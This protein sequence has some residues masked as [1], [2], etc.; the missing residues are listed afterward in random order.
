[1]EQN[2]VKIKLMTELANVL[3][4]ATFEYPSGDSLS[5]ES[6]QILCNTVEAL[7]IHGL[8]TAF[9]QKKPR[10]SRYP[11]PNFWPFVSK[12]T[13]KAVLDQI[14]TSNQIKTEIGKSRAW[15]R[16]LLNEN[17][18]ENYL[19]LLSRNNITLSKFY[20][21]WAFLR[22][23]E[24]MNVLS[25]Y[26]KGLTRL[27]IEAPV[28]SFFLNTWTPTPLIL[29]G[30]IA[31]EPA[32]LKQLT[33]CR[34]RGSSLSMLEDTELAENAL[35]SLCSS[36][37][38][39]SSCVEDSDLGQEVDLASVYSHP[40]MLDEEYIHPSALNSTSS[41]ILSNPVPEDGIPSY[42]SCQIRVTRGAYRRIRRSSKS[43]TAVSSSNSRNESI[44]AMV[45]ESCD[46]ENVGKKVE[47]FGEL[48]N[49]IQRTSSSILTLN[50]ENRENHDQSTEA[51]E[52]KA[53]DKKKHKSFEY[54][55]ELSISSEFTVHK[56]PKNPQGN[57]KSWTCSCA[58]SD[59]APDDIKPKYSMQDESYNLIY[60]L[61]PVISFENEQSFTEL[62]DQIRSISNKSSDVEL[63][64][65]VS[66][67]DNL[68]A[69]DHYNEGNSL[70]G[71]GWI[72]HHRWKPEFFD[73]RTSTISL[74]TN[75]DSSQNFDMEIR[76]VLDET[77]NEVMNQ[78]HSNNGSL[79]GEIPILEEVEDML[80]HVGDGDKTLFSISHHQIILNGSISE[81]SDKTL[82]DVL[83]VIPREKGLDSQDFRCLSC[84]KSIGPTFASYRKCGFDEKYYCNGC[85]SKGDESI[86][87]SRLI[88]NWD[89]HPRHV[90][91]C[92]M[93]FIES[94]RDKAV[95]RLDQINPQIYA[96]SHALNAV[97]FLREKLSLS[98]MYL[99][100][101]RKSIAE[102]L[103][104]RISP[105]D[106]LYKDIHLYSFTDLLTVLSGYMENHLNN[107]F[108]FTTEHIRRCLL[109]SQKGFLCEI[110]ASAEV[111]Y[112]FQLE[113]TSR[114]LACFSVYHKNCLEKQRCPKCTRR[115]R[116]MQQQPNID[117]QY[118]LLDMD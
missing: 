50:N 3:K 21:K 41:P 109:C 59:G 111:I 90:C 63:E 13:H 54:N 1:M 11:E 47:N 118:L 96:H 14:A 37:E 82:I 101:C 91:R 113:V 83:T 44:S 73:G 80:K 117:S 95:L 8:K 116:Y 51:Y 106:Y 19:N 39:S 77:S 18:I 87:P 68:Y 65:S 12:Y 10:S 27:T 78:K 6:T 24:R 86:I 94:I 107:L 100:S 69:S 38:I 76:N 53:V 92:N 45:G 40:S 26:M 64:R 48:Y 71:K 23:T 93:A 34:C 105:K 56:M 30:L 67:Q 103:E 58:R 98:A 17:T 16:I 57:S 46:I 97:K 114:C 7:F 28:N 62:G 36:T 4:Q 25:G 5:K 75:P 102:D 70:L 60:N 32:R 79:N 31:G 52:E 55:D 15:I 104:S 22:D 29:S 33:K 61:C 81:F 43:S 88:R 99:Q 35:H 108:N 84:R 115:E 74:S 66:M 85:F 110:C 2:E 89:R 20:E 112:P 72:V 42:D 9:F 49:D